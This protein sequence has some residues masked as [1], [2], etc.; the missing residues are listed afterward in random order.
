[1]TRALCFVIHTV[2]IYLLEEGCAFNQLRVFILLWLNSLYHACSVAVNP[3]ITLLLLAVV[4][5][6]PFN[7]IKTA[8]VLNTQEHHQQAKIEDQNDDILPIK[9]KGQGFSSQLA[10]EESKVV[11]IFK[12]IAILWLILKYRDALTPDLLH[13][14]TC[15]EAD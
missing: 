12:S 6:K 11:G 15:L 14:T 4:T 13:F 3:L 9:Q 8:M 1:M 5:N 10:S 2:V 7:S